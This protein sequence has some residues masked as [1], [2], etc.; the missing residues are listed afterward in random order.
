MAKKMYVGNLPFTTTES[1][2]VELFS[3]Y[4][5]VHSVKLISDHETGK[6]RGFGFVEMD[7]HGADAAIKELSG[8]EFAGRALRINEARD[9]NPRRPK[10]GHNGLPLTEGKGLWISELKQRVARQQ[11]GFLYDNLY[12]GR[13]IG[14]M[15]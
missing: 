6:L 1:Q 10:I 14:V 3:Q 7:D 15:K 2:V 12:G 13:A 8:K 9:R 11:R 4:G 5:K